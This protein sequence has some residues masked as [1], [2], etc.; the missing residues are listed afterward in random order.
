MVDELPELDVLALPVPARRAAPSD[1]SRS[2]EWA[3]YTVLDLSKR[4]LGLPKSHLSIILQVE[5][6]LREAKP[7]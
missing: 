5:A 6:E 7:R 1:A 3:S 4:L 2:K